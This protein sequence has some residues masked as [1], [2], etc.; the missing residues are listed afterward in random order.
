MIK[1]N[2]FIVFIFTF[3]LFVSE[4][5]FARCAVCYTNGMSGASIALI[6]IITSFIISHLIDHRR[7]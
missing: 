1:I 5:T 7:A 6:I 3:S 4:T 2:N